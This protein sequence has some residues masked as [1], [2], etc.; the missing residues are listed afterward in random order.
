MLNLINQLLDIQLISK[1]FSVQTTFMLILLLLAK[2]WAVTRLQISTSGWILLM[3]I[4]IPYC[5]VHVFL[6][7]WKTVSH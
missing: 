4:W 2:G 1:F 6:Y 5:I 7:V 3:A